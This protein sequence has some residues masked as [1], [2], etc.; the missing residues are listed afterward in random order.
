ML[1][2]VNH[3]PMIK[4]AEDRTCCKKSESVED[5]LAKHRTTVERHPMSVVDMFSFLVCCMD[6][7]VRRTRELC[8]N[9]ACL[10]FNTKYQCLYV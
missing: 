5:K 6:Y 3:Y 10:L 7:G 4:Y 2:L 1:E 8:E 9:K